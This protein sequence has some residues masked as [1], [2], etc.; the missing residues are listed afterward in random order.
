M[1]GLGADLSFVHPGLVHLI[2]LALAI[3]ALLGWQELRGRESLSRFVSA[4]MQR[5]LAVQPSRA[6]RLVRVGLCGACMIFGV[7]ALMRPQTPGHSEALRS[8]EIAA[9]IV[10]AL[11]VSRS[12]LADDVAPTRL[13][14]AKAEISDMV[15]KLRGHRVGLVGFAGRA[16]VLSPLTSDE[17]FFRMILDGADTRSISRG[18]TEIGEA[19]R[20]AVRAFEP[21]PGAKLILLITDGEDHGGYARDAAQEAV[22]AGVRIVTIGFGSEDGSPITLVDPDTGARTLLTDRDGKPV[23]SRLDG[24]LLRAL[25]LTTEGA[26]VPAGISA[27]DLEAIVRD[28]IEPIAL[29][30]DDRPMVRQVPNEYYPWFVL[31]A[32]FCLLAAAVVG[33]FTSRR[34]AL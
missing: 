33:T 16:A 30:A 14:R 12:M 9:D 5:R 8:G 21:G 27:L 13:D 22:E 3:T 25:A 18:G 23:N 24:E 1:L 10:V 17:G 19:I 7:I 11:D 20:K 2:W 28:H 34:Q 26:Y 31:L 6:Q 15:G 4:L 29:A 32:F